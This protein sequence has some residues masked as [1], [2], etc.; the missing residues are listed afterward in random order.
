MTRPDPKATVTAL[1]QAAASGRADLD[2]LR[3]AMRAA[4]WAA[5]GD[6][7]TRKELDE[8]LKAVCKVLEDLALA[9]GETCGE[10]WLDR[11]QAGI[12]RINGLQ[13]ADT[14]EPAAGGPAA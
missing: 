5:K 11:V 2:W 7:L 12:E 14:T 10:H 8:A 1:V 13:R 6:R 9:C 3:D 4:G